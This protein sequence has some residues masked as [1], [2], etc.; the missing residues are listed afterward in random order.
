RP[1]WPA[2]WPRA[3]EAANSRP[4]RAVLAW[5]RLPTEMEADMPFDAFAT[6]DLA[7]RLLGDMGAVFSAPLVLLGDRL[8]LY[9][10]LAAK[11]PLS[12]AE[13]AEETGTFERYVREWLAAQAA[14]G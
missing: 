2:P 9:K 6:P 12:P 5:P 8:G 13:L 3:C 7:T 14:A 10:A 11:G 4:G 1:A